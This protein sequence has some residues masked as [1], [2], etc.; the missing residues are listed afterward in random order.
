MSEPPTTAAVPPREPWGN[1]TSLFQHASDPVFLLSRRR[2]LRFVNHAWEKLTNRS[3]DQVRGQFCLPSKKKG[4]Q[5]LRTLLQCLAPTPEVLSGRVE[6]R[7][8]PAPPVRLGPPWWDITFVPLHEGELLTAVL[9]FIQVVGVQQAAAPALG[10]SEAIISLRQ[11]VANRFS[12]DLLSSEVAAMHRVESQA[13]LAAR[14]KAPV[15]IVGAAGVGKETLARVIHF[16]GVTREQIFL[17]I[18]CGGLQ[19]FLIQSMLFGDARPAQGR[20]GTVFLKNPAAL[21]RD[22]QTSILEWIDELDDPPRIIVASRDQGN[23]EVRSGRLLDEFHSS[24][25]VLEI[26]LPPLRDRL[27]DLASLAT[28][29]LRR[30]D[31]KTVITLEAL[32]LLRQHAWPG[33]L[34]E[35]ANVLREAVRTAAGGQIGPAHLPL[36]LR[37]NA[38][39]VAKPPLPLDQVLEEVETRLIRLALQKAKGNKSDAAEHLGIPRARLQRRLEALKIEGKE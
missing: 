25:N 8:R 34:S 29:F 9:G 3:F 14:T 32:A 30:Y 24:F 2:Q 35:F 36:E 17:P 6:T 37:L 26:R 1:W 20:L 5:P 16:Q 22:L 23:D 7:R 10:F 19:P 39:P 27:V 13:R 4:T 31:E 18:D 21:P 15:W 33:N 12:F 38:A 28:L 11:G